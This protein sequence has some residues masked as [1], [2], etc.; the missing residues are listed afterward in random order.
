VSD[1]KDNLISLK[2]RSS[3]ER[4][5]IAAKGGK[6]SGKSKR[7]KKYV[8]EIYADILRDRYKLPPDET[9]KI[10]SLSPDKYVQKVI[11]N[12]LERGDSSTVAMLDRIIKYTEG[13]NGIEDNEL[14][15]V[16]T[17]DEPIIDDDESVVET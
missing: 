11:R 9:G 2:D 14:E 4:K 12:V 15:I 6:A 1:G 17:D 13:E 3:E 8:S 5:S 7:I 10:K 16:I